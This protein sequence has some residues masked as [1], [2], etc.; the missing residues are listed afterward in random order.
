[1]REAAISGIE[2]PIDS[3]AY[4]KDQEIPLGPGLAII[5]TRQGDAPQGILTRPLSLVTRTEGQ[6]HSSTAKAA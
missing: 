3:P 6:V 1:L 4:I 5:V 2:V